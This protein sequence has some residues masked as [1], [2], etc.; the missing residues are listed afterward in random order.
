MYC[1]FQKYA[2]KTQFPHISH[3]QNINNDNSNSDNNK[4]VVIT[5]TDVSNNAKVNVH[6]S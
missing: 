2:I 4:K 3:I 1:P 6:S 5:K